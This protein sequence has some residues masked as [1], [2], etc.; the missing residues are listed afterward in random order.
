MLSGLSRQYTVLSMDF[1]LDTGRGTSDRQRGLRIRWVYAGTSWA[2]AIATTR[3]MPSDGHTVS[4]IQAQVTSV[5]PEPGSFA[6]LSIGLLGLAA[7]SR[8]TS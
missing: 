2:V 5:V 8:R 6:L 1:R 7:Y 3:E 4:Y